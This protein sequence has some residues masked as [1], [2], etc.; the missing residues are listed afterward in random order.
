MTHV[1]LHCCLRTPFWSKSPNA[2]HLAER[3][4]KHIGFPN[5]ESF[6]KQWSPCDHPQAIQHL[7]FIYPC[8]RPRATVVEGSS[9]FDSSRKQVPR[10]MFH[11]KKEKLYCYFQ[12]MAPCSCFSFFTFPR[13]TPP[14]DSRPRHR[15]R[16]S[17]KSRS[18]DHRSCALSGRRRDASSTLPPSLGQAIHWMCECDY[19]ICAMCTENL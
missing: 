14:R 17:W 11:L 15:R 12:L 13:L 5:N 18:A 8:P 1:M 16:R 6:S 2:A 3:A 19:P 9:A 4:R 10:V 7:P